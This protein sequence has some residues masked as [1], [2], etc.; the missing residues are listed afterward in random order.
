MKNFILGALLL[1]F[2]YST[3][4]IADHIPNMP[5]LSEEYHWQ[6]MPVICGS[7]KVMVEKMKNRNM[8]PVEISVGKRNAQPDGEVVFAV[9]F[10]VGQNGERASLMSVPNTDETCLIYISFDAKGTSPGS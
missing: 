1:S 9:M 4:A 3:T 5:P 7:A 2:F 8:M 6:Q 10:F